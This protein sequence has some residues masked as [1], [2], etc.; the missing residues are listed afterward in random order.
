MNSLTFENHDAYLLYQAAMERNPNLSA[1]GNMSVR[2][3]LFLYYRTHPE[4]R[5]RGYRYT[6]SA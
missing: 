1:K 4:E 5:P 6:Q 2:Y 3:A